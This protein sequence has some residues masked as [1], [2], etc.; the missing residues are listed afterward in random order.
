M[1]ARRGVR[2]DTAT[3]EKVNISEILSREVTCR[4]MECQG[5]S[6]LREIAQE[7]RNDLST[8]RLALLQIAHGS[9]SKDFKSR[10]AGTALKAIAFKGF[11][12]DGTEVW[13]RKKGPTATNDQAGKENRAIEATEG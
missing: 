10:L 13:D 7:L 12:T 4:C 3:G 5:A 11:A 9:H 2:A 8:A 6:R 1:S